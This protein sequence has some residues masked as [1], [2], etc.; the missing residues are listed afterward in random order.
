MF[1]LLGSGKWMYYVLAG[2]RFGESSVCL[3][4]SPNPASVI[5]TVLFCHAKWGVGDADSIGSQRKRD[6]NKNKICAFQGGGGGQG[7]REE[8]CPKRYFSWETS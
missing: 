4:R 1:S 2:T 6:D 5:C 3:G 8:N 7:G